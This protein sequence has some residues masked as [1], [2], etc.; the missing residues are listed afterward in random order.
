MEL[1]ELINVI[2]YYLAGDISEMDLRLSLF[3]F[4][5]TGEVEYVYHILDECD[6]HFYKLLAYKYYLEQVIYYADLLC[7]D[8]NDDI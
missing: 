3:D 7:N 2:N 5:M 1:T 8:D 4:P 6:D